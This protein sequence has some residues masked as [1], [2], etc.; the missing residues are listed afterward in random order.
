MCT[1]YVALSD[2]TKWNAT[3]CNKSL[4]FHT[5]SLW[6]S[7]K[8]IKQQL[9]FQ[10]K[11]KRT[12]YFHKTN[13]TILTTI[14]LACYFMCTWNLVSHIK[15]TTQNLGVREWGAKEDTRTYVGGS[16]RRRG[17]VEKLHKEGLRDLYCSPNIVWQPNGGGWDKKGGASGT[18]WVLTWERKGT[19]PFGRRSPWWKNNIKM[20]LKELVWEDVIGLRIWTSGALLSTWLWNCMHNLIGGGTTGFWR[21][22]LLRS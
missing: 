8:G 9:E 6:Q 19:R 20:N 10:T 3:F 17:G 15:R 12:S 2:E 22:S 21:R 7:C 11:Y 13:S 4:F 18:Y 5:L 14:P 1:Q 16:D